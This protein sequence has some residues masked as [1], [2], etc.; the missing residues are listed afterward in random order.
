[1][2]ARKFEDSSFKT[3]SI[4]SAVFSIQDSLQRVWFF[5]NIFLLAKINIEIVL[6]MFF[7]GPS[8]TDVKFDAREL[9]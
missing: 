3:Y 9:T 4:V 6:E 7:L 8:N 5:E 2:R 1:M